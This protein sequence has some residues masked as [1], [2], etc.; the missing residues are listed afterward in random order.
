[1][2]AFSFEIAEMRRYCELRYPG[3]ADSLG[4]RTKE[5]EGQSGR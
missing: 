4:V 5:H 2:T 1:M 3:L